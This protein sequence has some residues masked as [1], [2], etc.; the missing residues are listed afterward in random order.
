M[1]VPLLNYP[2]NPI[3]SKPVL[4]TPVVNREKNSVFNPAFSLRTYFEVESSTICTLLNKM[5]TNIIQECRNFEICICAIQIVV[6]IFNR[7]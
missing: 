6:H 3:S 2:P 1:Y 7:Q 4:Y 5:F